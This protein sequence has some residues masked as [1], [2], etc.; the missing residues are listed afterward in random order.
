MFDL[1]SGIFPVIFVIVIGV[2]LFQV[3]KGIGE[4]SYNNKQPVLTVKAQVVSKRNHVSRS[5]HHHNDHVHHHT[6]TT[7]YVTF[8]VESGDRMELRVS[9]KQYGL[10]AEG[11]LGQLTFQGTRYHGFE[12]M[13]VSAWEQ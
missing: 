1:L 8:E 9:G 13:A 2:I 5:A 10:L 12:R 4:W 7:Y 11:D 6:D 3:F